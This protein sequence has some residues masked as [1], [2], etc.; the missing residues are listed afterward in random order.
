MQHGKSK[1]FTHKNI[2]LNGN[3]ADVLVDLKIINFLHT[4][5]QPRSYIC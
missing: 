3:T 1:T 5:P 4:D 2:A